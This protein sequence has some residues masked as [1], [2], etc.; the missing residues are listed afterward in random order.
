MLA[1]HY[2]PA[3]SEPEGEPRPPRRP[4][5]LRRRHLWTQ[6]RR[7][8]AQRVVELAPPPRR[9]RIRDER[10]ADSLDARHK[11]ERT[12]PRVHAVVSITVERQRRHP[13][14][15]LPARRLRERRELRR[16]WFP[17]QRLHEPAAPLLL[18]ARR[19]RLLTRVT[20]GGRRR[21]L[22]DV[23]EDRLRQRVE[24]LRIDAGFV[25]RA[26]EAAPR[27]LRAGAVGG[28]QRVE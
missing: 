1:R 25:P 19:P 7:H 27:H 17:Q 12:Q 23:G 13:R 3:P 18:L 5:R 21:D 10:P 20:L 4:P 28:E 22:V 15:E 6:G 11:R 9:E 16:L 26:S 14:R 24:R 2:Q 8:A